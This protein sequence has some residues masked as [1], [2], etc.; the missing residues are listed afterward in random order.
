M[1]AWKLNHGVLSLF[2]SIK[3]P[4][5]I[6]LDQRA[7]V[8]GG[9]T[10]ASDRPAAKR[11]YAPGD[12]DSTATRRV[13]DTGRFSPPDCHAVRAADNSSRSVQ[14]TDMA[15]SDKHNGSHENLRW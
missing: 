15:M 10:L 13:T 7:A 8:A 1:S 11:G 6:A 9:V 12:D 5:V 2:R 4:A 14:R 3:Q